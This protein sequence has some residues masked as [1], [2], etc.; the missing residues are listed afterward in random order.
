MKYKD[1]IFKGKIVG[2]L[3]EDG[4]VYKTIRK[5]IHIMHKFNSIG[6]TDTV[7]ERVLN[8]SFHKL[9]KIVFVLQLGVDKETSQ[10]HIET[11][12]ISY[13][14]FIIQKDVY[15]DPQYGDTQFHIEIDY[16]REINDIPITEIPTLYMG[17]DKYE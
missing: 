12:G 5:P 6:I 4:F 17:G 13:T 9:K 14:D 8:L 10:N 16:L 3:R 1:I 7:L 2:S 11:L 15:R